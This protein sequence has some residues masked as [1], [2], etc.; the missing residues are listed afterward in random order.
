MSAVAVTIQALLANPAVTQLVTN[1]VWPSLAPQDAPT[2]NIIVHRISESDDLLLR[3]HAQFP[4]ARISVECRGTTFR[5]ADGLGEAV[6]AALKPLHRESLSGQS[7]SFS[8]QGTDV[9]GFADDSKIH[10]RILDFY[11]RRQ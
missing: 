3:G 1:R 4:L 11:V 2:P 10:T 8:K 5:A 7:V 6:D 9:S